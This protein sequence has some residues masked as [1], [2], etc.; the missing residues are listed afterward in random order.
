MEVELPGWLH[1][2]RLQHGTEEKFN[3]D[4]QKTRVMNGFVIA[5]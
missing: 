1:A 5:Q 3:L 2:H 4:A